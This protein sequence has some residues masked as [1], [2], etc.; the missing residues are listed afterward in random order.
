MDKKLM[1]EWVAALVKDGRSVPE[2]ERL[3]K[4]GT[5]VYSS[6]AEYLFSLIE[7]GTP[8]DELPDKL[9]LINGK[10]DGI[11]VVGAKGHESIICYCL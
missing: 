9:D 5:V 4:N 3:I 11:V 8:L 6:F 2:A 7:A 10:Y 1:R